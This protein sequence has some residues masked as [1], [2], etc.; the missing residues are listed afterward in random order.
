[1]LVFTKKTYTVVETDQRCIL[2]C[3]E[4]YGKS[5]SGVLKI[6]LPIPSLPEFHGTRRSEELPQ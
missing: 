5:N 2:I 1:M 4:A 6:N 3:K